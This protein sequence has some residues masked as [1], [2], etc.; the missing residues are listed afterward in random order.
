VRLSLASPIDGAW[1][2]DNYFDI[3]PGRPVEILLKTDRVLDSP[4]EQIRVL[5]LVETF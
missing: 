4:L 5:N 3:L 1:F 2:S